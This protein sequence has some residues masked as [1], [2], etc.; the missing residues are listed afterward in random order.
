[1]LRAGLL[2]M[3]LV[4]SGQGAQEAAPATGKGRVLFY[5][6]GGFYYALRDC[7]LFAE[8]AGGP[9]R[10]AAL[11]GGRYFATEVDPGT[12]RFA[13]SDKLRRAVAVEVEAG[14]T[15]YVRCHFSGFPG[16][17]RLVETHRGEFERVSGDLAPAR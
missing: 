11:G 15:H 8:A 13:A 2:A 10:L 1:M 14:R 5:R 6:T 4:A 12:H 9:V 7:P 17:P 16:S 3:L